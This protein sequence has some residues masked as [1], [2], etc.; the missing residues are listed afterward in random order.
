MPRRPTDL[1]G[2]TFGSLVVLARLPAQRGRKPRWTCRCMCG[3][4]HEVRSTHLLSGE[5]ISCGCIGHERAALASRLRIQ[6]GHAR[7]GRRS[8][9]WLSWAQAN[10]RCYRPTHPKYPSYGG[11]GITMCEQ[12]RTSFAT[13]LRDV[14]LRPAPDLSL[15]RIDNNGPY[16]PGNVRWATRRQQQ[17]NRRCSK[18]VVTP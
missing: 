14:G 5:V 15:D 16:A 17:N 8:P 13:F 7:K 4:T 11:R 10:A 12:W 18:A 1:Q 9:E 3:S 2:R 6:H